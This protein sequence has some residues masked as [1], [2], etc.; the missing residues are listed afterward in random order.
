MMVSFEFMSKP[1]D[2]SKNKI[3]V[4]CIENHSL[5]RK[6]VKNFYDGCIEEKDIVFS[7]NYSKISFK[8]N[9]CF[10]SDIFSIDFSGAFMKKIYEDLS[11][12][13][14]TFLT[15]DTMKIKTN[16]LCYLE[17]LSQS[18]D[19]DFEFKDELDIIDLMK[20][21]NFKPVVNGNLLNRLLDFMIVIKKY[22]TVKCFVLLNIHNCFSADELNQLYKELIYQNINILLIENKKYFVSSQYEKIYIVDEDLC[23]IID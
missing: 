8:N 1:I 5:Y 10:I 20:I 15:E 13:A 21:Q 16:V 9:V 17:M 23:E 18:Y 2:L 12:H 3:S 11:E 22:S 14:N 6:T 19:F 7:E 4:L